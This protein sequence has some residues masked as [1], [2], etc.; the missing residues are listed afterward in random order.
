MDQ[1]LEPL[2]SEEILPIFNKASLFGGKVVHA[3]ST[4]MKYL[5][6]TTFQ[7]SNNGLICIKLSE[8]IILQEKW[9]I[10]VRLNYRNITFQLEPDNYTI[11][12]ET[13][14]GTLPIKAKA[15]AL[16][17]NER[18]AMPLSS[19]IK[20]SFYRIENRGGTVDIIA[21]VLDVSETGLGIIIDDAEED[22]LK[23]ND[24]FWLKS[25]NNLILPEPIFGRLVYSFQ[26]RFKDTSDLKAGLS[27]S[28]P[29][30]EDLMMRLHKISLITLKG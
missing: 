14:T 22:L 19:D 21:K 30:S 20:T 2:L 16:R 13:I 5:N 7:V 9:P 10:S 6:I 12:G 3:T 26:R 29:L 28:S 23:Q 11:S 24:H 15:I 4:M 18:Y 8:E 25:I 27:L 1:I 17:A